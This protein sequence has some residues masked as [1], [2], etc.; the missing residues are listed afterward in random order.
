MTINGRMKLSKGVLTTMVFVGA[1]L[2]FGLEP[3][4]GR[5]LVPYYGGAVYVWLTC[6]MFFQAMLVLGYSYAHL[7]ARKLGSW[8]LM[9]LAIPFVNLPLNLTAEPSTQGSILTLLAVLLIQVALPFLMLSTTAIVAQAWLAQSFLAKDYA[10]YPLYAASNAGSLLALLGYAFVVEPLFG[11]RA[12]S[13]AWTAI[14]AFYTVLVIVTWFLLRPDPK[15]EK[16]TRNEPSATL[17]EPNPTVPH[18]LQWLLLSGLPSAFLLAVTNFIALE[19]G[20]F[21]M[22]WVAPLALYLATFVVTFARNGGVPKSL[23]VIWPE[24]ILLGLILYLLPKL[25]PVFIL[26]HLAILSAVCLVAHGNLYESR[27]PTRYLTNFYLTIAIGGWL[28]GTLIILIAPHLFKGFFEYPIL[29]SALGVTYLSFQFRSFTR[30]FS[31]AS[32]LVRGGRMLVMSMMFTFIV[33]GAWTR[34]Q[35]PTLFRHRNFYGTYQIRDESTNRKMPPSMRKLIHGRT[36]HGAQLLNPELRLTPVAYYYRGSGIS[37]VYE[38]TSPPRQIAVVGLGSGAVAVY[39]AKDD[40][41]TFYEIDPDNERIA[42]AWFTYLRECKGKVSVVVGDGR[43][44]M[45]K[46]VRDGTMFDIIMI[47]AF[48]GDGIPSHLLTQEA[49]SSYLSRLAPRGIMLFHISNRYYDLRPVIKST[50]STLKLFGAM[51]VPVS[52]ERLESFQEPD[53]CVVLTRSPDRLEPLVNR[54]WIGMGQADGLEQIAPWTDDYINVLAP[55]MARFKSR[56]DF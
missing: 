22:V 39:V 21:P 31:K 30:F 51:N 13:R 55:L 20:S 35:Q 47:D 44:S 5:L 14:Y 41:I 2:L 45:R 18:Y 17:R 40:S 49:L 53:Q 7:L 34:F 19:V 9:M 52:K 12:Q 38:T 23:N 56:F 11:L 8:H 27:P 42:R 33:I 16:S 26:G 24:V 48:T 32:L 50:A 46:S 29:L 25:S 37:D 15:S 54:G 4:V 28:G 6:L 43:L 36:L 10:P 3:L 1:V